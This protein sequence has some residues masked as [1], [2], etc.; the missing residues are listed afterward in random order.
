MIEILRFEVAGSTGVVYEVTAQRDAAGVRIGCT[1]E[2]ANN[3]Q[4]CRHR[5]A[6]LAGDGAAMISGHDGL[7][8]LTG[9]LPGT[10]LDRAIRMVAEAEGEA[11]MAK[12]KLAGAR[13]ALGRSMLGG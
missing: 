7:T 2:A 8:V 9:W 6:L 3:K 4:A 5:S 12:R 11:E 1:C 13:K 10:A